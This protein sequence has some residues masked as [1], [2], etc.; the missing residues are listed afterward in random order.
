M[1]NFKTINVEPRINYANDDAG[2]TESFSR[3]IQ[4]VSNNRSTISPPD[5]LPNFQGL[6]LVYLAND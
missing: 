2:D 1:Q 3:L 6:I 4:N 5:L